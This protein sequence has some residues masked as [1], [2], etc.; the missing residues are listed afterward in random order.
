MNDTPQGEAANA[1]RQFRE[2][3]QA[4]VEKSKEYLKKGSAAADDAASAMQNSF[5]RA[6]KGMQD[7]NGKLLEFARTNTESNVSFM[8][9]VAGVKSPSEFFQLYA[10]HTRRQ[11]EVLTRQSAELAALTRQ[12][13]LSSAEPIKTEVAKYNPAG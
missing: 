13:A 11:L 12:M 7:Y 9:S 5:S 6:V 1:G 8:Q 3:T 2:M 10:E 4:G